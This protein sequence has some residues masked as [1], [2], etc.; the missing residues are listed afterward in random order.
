[1][2]NRDGTETLTSDAADEMMSEVWHSSHDVGLND[3]LEVIDISPL[4]LRS[5]RTTCRRAQ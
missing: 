2:G 5:I 3:I 4:I 1:M